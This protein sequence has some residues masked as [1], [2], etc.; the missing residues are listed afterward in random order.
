MKVMWICNKVPVFVS[1]IEKK[2]AS[3][4]GGWLE[5]MGNSLLSMP[6]FELCIV[7]RDSSVRVF[8]SGKLSFYS[9]KEDKFEQQIKKILTDE[10]PSIIHIWGTEFNHANETLK[11]CQE[12]GIEKKCVVSIQGLVSLCGKWHYTEGLPNKIIKRYTIRDFIRRDNIYKARK[13]FLLRGEKE[14]EALKRTNHII[15]RTDF[16]MAAVQ[17]FNPNASYHFCNETL[18]NAFYDNVWD[19]NKIERHS[20]FVS[21]CGYP[22]K[23]FHYILEAMPYILQKYPDAHLYTTGNDLIHLTAK[24]KLIINS[25]QSYLIKLIRRYK[26]EEHVSFLG[27]LT[28]QEMCRQ[29]LKANVFVSASTIENSPNSVGEAML[30]G[31]PVVS[32]DVGG[33]K[34]MLEHGKEGFIYQSSAPYMLAYYVKK[35]FEDDDLALKFSKNAQVHANVSHNREINMKTLCGIYNEIVKATGME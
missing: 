27:F 6:D 20:I 1:H 22:I 10:N 34:N 23:G 12:L 24:E 9:F 31:C 7:A 30:V 5:T 15:G 21:Q 8:K 17:M 29:Y 3:Y 4:T 35:I 25:Y 26:L 2:Q 13:K 33:V 11:A 19:I 14:I 18:R 16:D 32:S 28:E